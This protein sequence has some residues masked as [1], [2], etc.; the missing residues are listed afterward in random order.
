VTTLY[1]AVER[2][3]GN[4]LAGKGLG[5]AKDRISC[6]PAHR[7]LLVG[8]AWHVDD[9]VVDTGGDQVF[10]PP[11]ALSTD[12]TKDKRANSS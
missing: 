6:K 4:S 2:T 12:A 11:A 10:D 9:D 7:G 3:R 1:Q 8:E 5:E